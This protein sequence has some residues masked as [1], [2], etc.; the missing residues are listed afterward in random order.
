MNGQ[1]F[2]R[3]AIEAILRRMR[4][5]SATIVENGLARTFGSGRPHAMVEI[6][7]P[8]VWAELLHGGRGLALAYADGLWDSPDPADVIRL[9]ALN[10]EPFDRTRR[11]LAPL[12][13]PLRRAAGIGRRNTRHRARAAIASH[14]DRGNELFELMLDPTM[15]YSC[16][17]FESPGASLEEASVAKLERVCHKLGLGPDDHVLEIGSGWGSFAVHAAREHGCRVTTTTLSRQQF[18]HTRELIAREGLGDRVTLLLEDYRD[19]QGRYD[20]LVSIEMIEAVGWKDFGTFFERCSALLEPD[21]TMLLQAIAIDDRAY[22]VEKHS[23]SFI[24]RLIFPDGCL[25][26]LKVISSCVAGHTDMRFIGLE[27]ISAHYVQTLRAWR[28]NL[29]RHAEELSHR[30]F[31][32]EFQR[33]WKFYLAYCEAG[34][35]ERRIRDL[36][37][38]LAKPQFREESSFEFQV[39]GLDQATRNSKPETRNYST[40]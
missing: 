38:L 12:R 33:L 17:F 37:V 35:A 13:A 39:S 23:A 25:P 31:D 11:A 7:S 6:H 26:S 29:E 20:K 2:G 16:G 21:G 9:C 27:D 24:R 5:G 3:R 32:V 34:F 1:R 36:Q 8:R 40:V 18:D 14:Y 30:G 10:I 15:T 28:A 22:E 19:L 4:V